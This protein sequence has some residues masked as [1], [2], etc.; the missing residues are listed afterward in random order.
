MPQNAN[1]CK[2][3]AT[4]NANTSQTYA[5]KNKTM[6]PT[7]DQTKE[8]FEPTPEEIKKFTKAF[9]DPEFLKLFGEYAAEISDPIKRKEYEDEIN[10]LE[11]ETNPNSAGIE[12]LHQEPHHF[13]STSDS[14]IFINIT[15]SEQIGQPEM[16]AMTQE[17]TGK[18][19]FGFQIPC[20]ISPGVKDFSKDLKTVDVCFHPD[21]LHMAGTNQEFM[22]QNV[23]M[24]A[25]EEANRH[26]K[27]GLKLD[28]KFIKVKNANDDK[29]GQKFIGELD[30]NIK[31]AKNAFKN[32]QN[33][34]SENPEKNA[35]KGATK[36]PKNDPIFSKENWPI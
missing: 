36:K 15:T 18:K 11:L 1:K 17:K 2:K 34:K 32:L 7:I 5:N 22:D 30:N 14:S 28:L 29:N 9:K 35:K 26:H 24:V 12:F 25:C 19:G 13:I 10:R 4:N 27:L 6:P 8:K 16:K 3:L 21:T 20:S 33:S 31:L 23:H